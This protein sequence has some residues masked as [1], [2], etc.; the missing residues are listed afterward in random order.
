MSEDIMVSI[1]CLTYNHS[2]YIKNAL[3]GFLMQKTNFK[4][5][6]I[7]H[8]DASTDA[9]ADIIREYEKKYPER[10]CSSI[11]PIRYLNRWTQI[12]CFLQG[13]AS[14]IEGR[15]PLPD[16]QATGKPDRAMLLRHYPLPE[17]LSFR[18]HILPNEC[19][20]GC[21][22]CPA[23]PPPCFKTD[24]SAF[25]IENKRRKNTMACI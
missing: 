11:S 22:L 18:L 24:V 16:E 3:D 8:D 21:C 14:Q 1:I 7:V 10:I 15:M 25:I 19:A 23:I 4:Y 12:R 13:R 9:T 20:K 17:Y 5:E 6:I 2:H